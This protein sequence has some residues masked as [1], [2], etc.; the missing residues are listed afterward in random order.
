MS[1]PAGAVGFDPNVRITDGSSP[2][3]HQVEPSLA[4]DAAGRLFVGWKEAETEE[5]QGASVG[6]SRSLNGGATW[7]ANVLM[8]RLY[9]FQTDPWLALDESGRLYF[10]RLEFSE[11]R[12]QRQGVAVSRSDDG[13]VTWGPIADA[14][15]L[16]VAFVDKSSIATSADGRA[17]VAYTFVDATGATIE[18]GIRVTRSVDGGVTWSSGVRINDAL[19]NSLGAV[20]AAGPGGTVVAAWWDST[21]ANLLSDRSPDGGTTWGADVRVNAV[22]ASAKGSSVNP[23]AIPLPTI[24]TTSLGT[25]LVAFAEGPGAD[26]DILIAQSSDGGATW[27][28]PVR[29][30][31]DRSGREQWQPALAVGPDDTVHL[32]WLDNR[33]GNY[34]VFYATSR[35]GRRWSSNLRVTDAETPST[36]RRPGDYLGLAVDATAVAYVAWTDGRLGDLDIFFARRPAP[37]SGGGAALISTFMATDRPIAAEARVP[38]E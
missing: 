2:S 33:T 20:L 10:A 28:R 19:H 38:R 3:P 27:S 22:G 32:A 11:A 7:S 13:G 15:D 12:F 6:V 5:G 17:Y 23:W 18:G 25:I 1:E 9:K 24:A 4:V 35:D 21:A 8:D 34:N 36:F 14:D 16:S 30:N 37:S 29:V 26:L 31:D